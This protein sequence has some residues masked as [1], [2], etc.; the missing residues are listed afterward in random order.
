MSTHDPR[1]HFGLGAATIVERIEVTWPGGLRTALTN[2]A[3]NQYV[4]ITR[5]AG[6]AR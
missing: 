4:K 5:T 2:V 3:V 1:L 6:D